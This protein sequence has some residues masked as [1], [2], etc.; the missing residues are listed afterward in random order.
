[1]RV[2]NKQIMRHWIE[3][4]DVGKAFLVNAGSRRNPQG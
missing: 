2:K 1:M 4:H 3:S